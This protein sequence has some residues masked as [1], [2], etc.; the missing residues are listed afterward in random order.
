M[1]K[2][3][4]NDD[5]TVRKGLSKIEAALL[6]ELA[7]EGKKV[8][9]VRDFKE[10]IGSPTR[11]RLI[12]SRLYKKR[13]LIR[14]GRGKYLITPLEA[15][16]RPRWTEDEVLIASKLVDPYYIGFSRAL[17][18]HSLTEQ[19]PNSVT[20]ATTKPRKNRV[21]NGVKYY[22]VTLNRRK[23]FGFEKSKVGGAAVIYSDLEKTVVDCLDHPEYC[24]GL[25]EVAKALVEYAHSAREEP[26]WSKVLIYA[27]KTGNGAI[28]KRLG[29]L[30]DVLKLGI[31]S[32]SV[33]WLKENL[34]KGYAPLSS[35]AKMK[36]TYNSKWR[37]ELNYPL[38]KIRSVIS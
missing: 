34:S 26:N 22:F 37:L 16:K 9:D 20:I 33:S 1:A 32:E 29:F 21:I 13:W 3:D 24:G 15:G 14:V 28:F 8:I 25:V 4:V 10:K 31:P 5:K 7:E 30:D 17:Y 12:A 36:G 35:G 11:A 19:V 27:K 23:F 2:N 38:E 6:S 18:Y